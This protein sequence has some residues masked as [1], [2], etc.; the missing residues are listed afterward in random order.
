M[1]SKNLITAGVMMVL[2]IYIMAAMVPSALTSIVN[3]CSSLWTSDVKTL[4][5]IIPIFIVIA[6]IF[7]IYSFVKDR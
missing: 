7:F 2:F 3:G 5:G 6:L 4:W 1:A